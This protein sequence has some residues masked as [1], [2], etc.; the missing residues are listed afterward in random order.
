MAELREAGDIEQDASVIIL[1]WNVNQDDYS[2]KGC[3][4]EKNRQGKLGKQVLNFD[5]DLMKF[6]ESEE[7]LKSAGEWR[8]ADNGNPFN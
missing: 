7:S 6:T 4:I 5:G 3:K 1:M 8:N 2:K